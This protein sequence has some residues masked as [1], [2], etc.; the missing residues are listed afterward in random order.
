MS[1]LQ[2]TCQLYCTLSS[3]SSLSRGDRLSH[4]A[5]VLITGQGSNVCSFSFR[6]RH[7]RVKGRG[8]CSGL[9]LAL[10]QQPTLIM[11]PRTS[12][13]PSENLLDK[14]TNVRLQRMT[15]LWMLVLWW[16]DK[17]F[18]FMIRRCWQ[19]HGKECRRLLRVFT[20]YTL[21]QEAAFKFRHQMA[22]TKP[23][24]QFLGLKC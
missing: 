22:P 2:W 15:N 24:L 18:S 4:H 5:P 21:L 13:R 14:K 9:I 23:I 11:W 7:S 20:L 12:S 19:C 17:I 16:H 6:L 3:V 8:L 1:P 10:G